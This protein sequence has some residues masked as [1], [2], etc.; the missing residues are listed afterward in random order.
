MRS[1]FHLLTTVASINTKM[2]S[3]PENSI[4]ISNICKIKQ[5][6]ALDLSNFRFLAVELYISLMSPQL[7]SWMSHA[8]IVSSD[9]LAQN[10]TLFAATCKSYIT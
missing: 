4:T 7:C 10:T 9:L 1:K 3:G 6:L 2:I 5:I 8:W